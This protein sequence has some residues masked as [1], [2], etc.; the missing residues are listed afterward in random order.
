MEAVPE[1]TWKHRLMDRLKELNIMG[2]M[3]D[4][5]ILK[6]ATTNSDVDSLRK[7]FQ[8]SNPETQ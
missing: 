5:D 1:N 2:T 7:R 6:T 8:Q 4:T 3:K